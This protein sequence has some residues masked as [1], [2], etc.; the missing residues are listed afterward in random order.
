MK[1]Y[2]IGIGGSIMQSNI[3][4][5]DLQFII[6][7]SIEETYDILRKNWYGTEL[8]MDEYKEISVID[9]YEII[10]EEYPQKDFLELYFVNMGGYKTNH[11]GELHEYGLCAANSREQAKKYGEETMLLQAD[12]KHMDNIFKV[13]DILKNTGDKNLYI[14]LRESQTKDQ[15]Q[16]D[17]SGYKIL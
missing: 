3:E 8:H 9:N 13:Q 10:L 17:W 6:A 11:F 2:A 1:L 7:N 5:H 4:V 14:H 15:F 12:D 16:P